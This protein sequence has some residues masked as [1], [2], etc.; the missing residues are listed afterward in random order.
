MFASACRVLTLAVPRLTL[1]AILSALTEIPSAPSRAVAVKSGAETLKAWPLRPSFLTIKV[2]S[3]RTT[4]VSGLATGSEMITFEWA[5]IIR[6]CPCPRSSA[7]PFSP[8]AIWVW[9]EITS[10]SFST[11]SC[12]V[13][14]TIRVMS[15]LPR[16]TLQTPRFCDAVSDALRPTKSN[17]VSTEDN[18]S[19]ETRAGTK[20]SDNAEVKINPNFEQRLRNG[21][22][23]CHP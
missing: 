19:E 14:A 11:R 20:L 13:P 10:P 8:A 6:L 12:G 2:P 3:R 18:G 5:P 16:T 9:P 22:S 15:P 1:T 4:S 7:Q 23:S 17:T 21:P